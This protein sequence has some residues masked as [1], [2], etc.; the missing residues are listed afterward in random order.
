MNFFR[1]P[2]ESTSTKFLDCF[3]DEY[4][5]ADVQLVSFCE[6]K[7]RVIIE[8]ETGIVSVRELCNLAG[9]LGVEID[10]LAIQVNRIDIESVVVACHTLCP[11][12]ESVLASIVQKFESCITH[13][14][15]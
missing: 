3:R 9:A 12:E 13:G 8:L 2:N 5:G 1:G 11:V 7:G 10:D 6:H 14:N 15:G 4:F